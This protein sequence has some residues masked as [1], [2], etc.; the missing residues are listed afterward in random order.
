MPKDSFFKRWERVI[1]P[2]CPSC[3]K[4]AY[5]EGKATDGRP[6]F[7]CNVCGHVWTCGMTGGMYAKLASASRHT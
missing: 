3:H 5:S 2:T 6:E 1:K 4:R 7:S